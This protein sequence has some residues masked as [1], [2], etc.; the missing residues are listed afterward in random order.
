MADITMPKM[1]FDMTEGTIVRWLKKVGD[2]VNK[3]EAVAEIETDKVTIEIE[4]FVSGTLSEIIS[5]AGSRTPVGG[6]IARTS[7]GAGAAHVAPVAVA[8]A[9]VAAVAAPG[10]VVAH[11]AAPV[12]THAIGDVKASPIAKRMAREHGLDLGT[13]HGS[14]PQGRIVRDDVSAAMI[15]RPAGVVAPLATP[16]APVVAAPLPSAAAGSTVVPL[17]NM[18]RTITRRLTQSWQTAPHFYITMEVNMDAALT[19]RKQVNAPL[20]KEQQISINDMIVKACGLALMAYPNLNASF[21]EEG[22]QRNPNVNVSI[23]VALESG[24]VAPVVTNADSRSLSAVSRE[25]KRLIGLARDGKL[26]AENL[27]GGTFTVSNLGMYGVTEFDAII[28]PPQCAILAVGAVRRIPVFKGE[29]NDVVAANICSITISADHR[30][31]DG[32]EGAKFVG[33]IKRLLENPLSMLI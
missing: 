10:V 8:V 16:V 15:G 23:A 24:L 25:S 31:T 5:P 4:S 27:Q 3:G 13:I 32:A 18:R 30:I 9:P 1:G 19:L 29:S 11:V 17:S 33:E 20:S 6:V 14:G 22:I 2:F 21:V 7:D 26:G 28:T 12:A